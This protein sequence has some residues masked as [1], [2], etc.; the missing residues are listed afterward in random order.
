MTPFAK[1]CRAIAAK[2][3]GTVLNVSQQKRVLEKSLR[4]AGYS[5]T[6]AKAIAAD[7]LRDQR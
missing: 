2:V 4:A 3:P 5:R 7:R 6:H 1:A